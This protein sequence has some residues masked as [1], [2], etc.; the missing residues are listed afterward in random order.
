[1]ERNN[2]P[3]AA[4]IAVTIVGGVM[5]ALFIVISVIL[6]VKESENEA[7]ASSSDVQVVVDPSVLKDPRI[8]QLPEL[9]RLMQYASVQMAFF[10]GKFPDDPKAASDPYLQELVT[11]LSQLADENGVIRL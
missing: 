11:V 7:V 5:M 3:L 6:L 9:Q 8:K 1:I 10:E 4:A 2:A